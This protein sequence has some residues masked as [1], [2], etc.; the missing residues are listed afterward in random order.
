MVR[1]AAVRGDASASALG[2]AVTALT[3]ALGGTLGAAIY[4]GTP[5]PHLNEYAAGLEPLDMT[6]SDEFASLRASAA[7]LGIEHAADTRYAS[8]GLIMRHLRFHYLEWGAPESPP[9]LLL[10]GGHQSGHSWDLVS[11]ALADRFHLYALDQRGH[12]DSEWAKD[13]NYGIDEMTEDALEFVRRMGLQAPIVMGHSMGGLVALT[14]MKR[15][16]E[17]MRGAVI[18]D[19]GPEVSPA[20]GEIIR[21]FVRHNVEF[22][23]L[24]AF[25]ESVRKYDPFR[26]REHIERT[27][28][29]NMIR[30]VDGTYVSKCD[31]RIE[32]PKE[33]TDA[34][35]VAEG[36]TL[37]D[38]LAIACPALVVRGEQSM[39]LEADAGERFAEALPQ[40]RIV[41]VPQCGHNVHS[42]NTVGFLEAVSPFLAGFEGS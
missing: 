7:D 28:R 41:T 3:G 13:K 29:Y 18:V 15:E 2:T 25:V 38:A 39:V 6:A 36:F 24:E 33:A 17:L 4:W 19:V 27:T 23:D 12:G 32:R 22:T 26:S 14:M 20:G 1:A 21:N 31:I 42:Q 30:R 9:I 40:G 10:H 16:P 37:D 8:R 34:E 11:L 5:M 35:P